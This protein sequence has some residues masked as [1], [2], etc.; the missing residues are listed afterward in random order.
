VFI[1]SLG[2]PPNT[3]ITAPGAGAVVTFPGGIRQEFPVVVRGTAKDTGGTTPGIREVRVMIQNLEHGE[4]FCGPPG[5]NPFGDI[6]WVTNV[7]T[8]KATLGQPAA[9]GTVPW[10]ISV[11]MYDHPHSYMVT[12]WAIDT[13]GLI[14]QSRA[15]RTFSVRDPGVTTCGGAAAPHASTDAFCALPA[16][17]PDPEASSP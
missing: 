12:A 10:S 1:D 9:D 8:P 17:M 3:T 15:S 6:R 5:C 14:E 16:V 13:N 11:P 2:K 7:V 4:Y